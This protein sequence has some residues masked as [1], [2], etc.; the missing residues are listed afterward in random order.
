MLLAGATAAFVPHA[1]K[2]VPRSRHPSQPSQPIAQSVVTPV[3]L[4]TPAGWVM[5]STEFRLAP[6]AY[7]HLIQEA[8]ERYKLDPAL[9]RAVI[10][11]ES[12]FDPLAVSEAGAQGLMQLMPDLAEELGVKDSFDPRENIMAGSRYLGYLMD[13]HKGNEALA[14]ASYNAGPSMVDRYHGVPPFEETQRYVKS[15][16]DIL[17]RERTAD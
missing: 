6:S 9:I 7:D 2:M 8:A 11:V 10:T 4:P 5:V 1:G 15:I 3:P 17:R 16:A 12:G 13:V 14:L